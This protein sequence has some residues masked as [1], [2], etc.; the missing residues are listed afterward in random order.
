[1]FKKLLAVSISLS[2]IL[3]LCSC[4]GKKGDINNS[5]KN[6]KEKV[7]IWTSGE[8]YKNDTYLKSLREKFKDFEIELEYMNSSTI[9]SKVLEEGKNSTCDIV[10]SEEYSYMD[11]IKDNLVPLDNLID[12]SIF[13]DTI[14][15]NSKKWTP[16]VK[17]G[18]CIMVNTK[19]LKE[20]GIEVPTSYNDLLD[21]KYKNLISMPSPASSGT[22]YMFLK[23][24]INEWGEDKAFEYFKNLSQN[25]LQYTSS[26]SGPVNQLIQGEV[27]IA[28]GMTSQGVTERNNGVD[29]EILFF[30]EGSPFSMYGNGI[31][32]KDNIPDNVYE[33]FKYLSVELC[34][35][36]NELYFPDQ[37]FKNFTPTVKG[38][39][40][41]IKY[42]DMSNDTRSEK[43][44]I[45]KKWTFS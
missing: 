44:R 15:P 31:V 29:L 33:V 41:N 38:F 2:L 25:I 12:F 1:M 22:G 9:A 39:P 6:A 21:E 10:L 34:K 11:M 7:V 19:M 40:T 45:L 13:L 36:N 16:E 42:G 30:E 17:N 20:K 23:Q 5:G 24:L 32:K 26:G 37:I 3:M 18:G 8:D 43:E 35:Q 27:A 14:V 28:I 4:N